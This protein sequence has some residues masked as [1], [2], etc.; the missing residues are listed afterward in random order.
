MSSVQC[1]A[2]K[3]SSFVGRKRCSWFIFNPFLEPYLIFCPLGDSRGVT[4]GL[5]GGVKA[6][7]V[8]GGYGGESHGTRLYHAGCHQ[9]YS[10]FH[11]VGLVF[12]GRFL[13]CWSM[14]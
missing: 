2:T 3:Y 6:V 11:N 14:W 10:S 13:S 5:A 8:G 7:P 9:V 1:K 4:L 12:V